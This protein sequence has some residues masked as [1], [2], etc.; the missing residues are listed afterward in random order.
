MGGYSLKEKIKK[1]KERLKQWNKEQFGDTS[2]RVQQLQKELN[3]LEAGSSG[4]QLT[5]HELSSHKKIQEDLW[6][7]AQA[8][9]SLVK[10]VDKILHAVLLLSVVFSSTYMYVYV[11][12][13]WMVFVLFHIVT[14]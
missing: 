7:A 5:P 12:T 1:L 14:D 2:K 9:E 10:N 4:R 3:N 11:S 6:T 13:A 8:H